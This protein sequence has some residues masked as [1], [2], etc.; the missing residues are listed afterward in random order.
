[1]N[2]AGKDTEADAG[3]ATALDDLASRGAFGGSAATLDDEALARLASLGYVGSGGAG[4]PAGSRDPKDALAD[5]RDYM[6]GTEAINRGDDAVGLFERLVAGDPSN[7]EFR[8]RLGQALRASKDL[9]GAERV[10]R[11]LIRRYPDFYLAHRR[12]ASLLTAM[13]RPRD[14]REV[15]LALEARGAPFVGIDARVAEAHLANDDPERALAAARAGLGET[16]GDV[17]LLVLSA[18]ASERLGRDD[19]AL[20]GYRDAVAARP[21]DLEALDRAV[22]LLKRLGRQAEAAALVR[23]CLRRSAGDPGVRSRLAGI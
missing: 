2:V 10:Y 21:S 8:L 15:W 20:A 6:L 22:A 11:D 18:R 17:E 7:P 9:A 12:L 16:P 1:V 13:G 14:G 19:E 5:Y 4:V 23:D 3:L